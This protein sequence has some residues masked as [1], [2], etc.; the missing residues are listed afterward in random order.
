MKLLFSTICAVSLG[1]SAP[2]GAQVGSAAVRPSQMITVTSYGDGAQ[3][4]VNPIGRTLVSVQNSDG[5]FSPF[6]IPANKVFVVTGLDWTQGNTGAP[7]KAETLFLHSQTDSGVIWPIVIAHSGGSDDSRA[8]GHMPIT[9][10]VF[11]AGE[12]MCYSVNT[13]NIG[14]AIA[15][16]HGYFAANR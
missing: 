16:V 7:N 15:L 5:T 12:T 1:V 9:G 6:T 11:K 10:V 4:G 2:A 3:C 8:G 14:S 13:G